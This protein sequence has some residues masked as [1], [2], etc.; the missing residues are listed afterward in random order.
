LTG[1]PPANQEMIFIE[2]YA[3][4]GMSSGYVD[5]KFW[6]ETAIPMLQAKYREYK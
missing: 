2:R 3:H 1:T 5:P 6:S 4:G